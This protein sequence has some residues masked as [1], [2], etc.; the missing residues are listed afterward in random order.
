CYTELGAGGIADLR[1]LSALLSANPARIL[2]LGAASS[3]RAARG[4]GP[5]RGVLLPGTRADLCVVS[6]GE[7]WTVQSGGFMSRGKCT[8]FAGKRLRGK[9]LMTMHGGRIVYVQHG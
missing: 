9:V 8:P 3:G 6:T 1:R 5:A 4:A 7:A 2:G